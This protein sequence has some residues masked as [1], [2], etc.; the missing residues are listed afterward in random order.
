[1]IYSQTTKTFTKKAERIVCMRINKVEELVGITKKNIRFYE[2]KGLINPARNEENRYRE[3]SDEDVE[4]LRKV[5]LLRQL[6]VPI[7]EIAKIQ[8]GYLTLEDCMRRHRIF[9]DREEENL[10]Q[11]KSI[12]SQIEESGAKISNLDT[13]K[14]FL[15]MKEM[16]NEGVR[17]MNVNSVDKKRRAPIISAITMIILMAATIALLVWA[18]KVDPIPIGIL[19]VIIAIPV[20]VIVGVL[21]ALKDRIRQI[22]GGEEDAARKY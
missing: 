9:L 22:E 11:K 19:A 16:E 10:R 18:Y 12:C 20:V 21:L 17:F 4:A 13:E 15:L 3:Y 2:E 1:M 6:S 8:K 5:K 14:Y 7:E